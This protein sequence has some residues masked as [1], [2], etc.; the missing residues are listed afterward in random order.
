[1]K[2]LKNSLAFVVAVAMAAL[3]FS[4]GLGVL[5]FAFSLIPLAIFSA[6]V[7]AIYHYMTKES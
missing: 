3:L 7:V 6:M 2:F 1:M 5:V 4:A